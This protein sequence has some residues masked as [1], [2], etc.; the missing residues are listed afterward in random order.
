MSYGPSAVYTVSM[1]SG[2]TL[3]SAITFGRAW[4]QVHIEIPTMTSGTDI[5]FKVSTDG[6]N[7]RRMYHAP[8]IANAA[9]GP[10]YVT[11]AVTNCIVDIDHRFD[12]YLKI[13]LSTAMTATPATFKI[14]GFS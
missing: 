9:P 1:A 7:F 2:V 6:V 14:L 11:S 13:E 5:Y 3:S 10:F 8:T 12:P 4:T